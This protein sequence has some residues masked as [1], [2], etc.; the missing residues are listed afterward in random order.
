MVTRARPRPR[1]LKRP[2]WRCPKC[3]HRFV[4]KNLW[5][6]CGRYDLR[7]HF[8]GKAPGLRLVFRAWLAAA[9]AAGPVTTYAQKTRIVIQVRVRFAGAVVYKDWLDATLWLKR[10]ATHPRLHRVEDFGRMGYGLHFRLDRPA[11]VDAAL[12]ALVR[13]AYGAAAHGPS[14]TRPR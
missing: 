7:D 10:K 11:Q 4:T 14:P 2:L 1:V 9:R 5:H 8:R 13:E 6:S 12:R 3:G